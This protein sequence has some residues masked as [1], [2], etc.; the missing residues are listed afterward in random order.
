MQHP[1]SAGCEHH[2]WR[3]GPQ[4]DTANATPICTYG[5]RYVEV[6]FGGGRFGWDFIMAAVSTPLLGADFLCAFNLLVDVNNCHLI[7]DL[8]FSLYPCMLGGAGDFCLLI[9]IAT[10]LQSSLTLPHPHSRLR[11]LSPPVYARARR[12]NSAKLAIAREEF[13]TMEC[14]GVVRCPNSPWAS[15]LHMVT[16]V[17]GSPVVISLA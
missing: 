9:S 8:S 17:A 12:L 10:C 6:C 15:P 16:K 4:M 1:A 7:D 13:S 2:G 14:L 5:T 3:H 11:G